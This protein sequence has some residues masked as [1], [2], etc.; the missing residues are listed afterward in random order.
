MAAAC[1]NCGRPL[2][3]PESVARGYG[4]VCAGLAGAEPAPRRQHDLFAHPPTPSP[5]ETTVRTQEKS[6]FQDEEIRIPITDQR[7]RDDFRIWQGMGIALRLLKDATWAESLAGMTIAKTLIEA[8]VAAVL[9]RIH[10]KTVPICAKAGVDLSAFAIHAFEAD[11]IVCRPFE[12]IP[13]E[14]KE[15]A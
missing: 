10:Q 8:E 13:A 6:L 11:A 14:M 2:T 1:R 9:A 15:G 3:D 7:L 12:E 4:P 5:Q